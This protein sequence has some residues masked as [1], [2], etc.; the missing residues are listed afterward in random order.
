MTTV[1]DVSE[2]AQI[3]RLL[4]ASVRLHSYDDCY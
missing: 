3:W 2:A 1:T 4:M